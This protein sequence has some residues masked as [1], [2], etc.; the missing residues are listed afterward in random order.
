MAKSGWIAAAS[1]GQ[2][3]VIFPG[4]PREGLIKQLEMEEADIKDEVFPLKHIVFKMT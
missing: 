1:N 2:R 3:S 4:S